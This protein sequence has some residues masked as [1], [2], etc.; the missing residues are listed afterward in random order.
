MN[1]ETTI[2]LDRQSWNAFKYPSLNI[3]QTLEAITDIAKMNSGR[4]LKVE[5]TL[6]NNIYRTETETETI[7]IIPK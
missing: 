4:V 7:T 5:V 6:S 2:K 1:K 3:K